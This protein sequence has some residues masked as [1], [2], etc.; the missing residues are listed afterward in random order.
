MPSGCQ[1]SFLVTRVLNMS[2]FNNNTYR[3]LLSTVNGTEGI[4]QTG[5]KKSFDHDNSKERRGMN[6]PCCYKKITFTLS[7]K[8]VTNGN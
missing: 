2:L 4:L 5:F 6:L 8:H 3:V 1:I 7:V